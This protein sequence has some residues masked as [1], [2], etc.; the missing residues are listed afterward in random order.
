MTSR[1]PTQRSLNIWPRLGFA[2]VAGM[3][4]ALFTL[5]G[6]FTSVDRA[7]Q[8][9]VMRLAH[10]PAASDIVL[11]EIDDSSLNAYGSWP[12]SRERYVTLIKALDEAG[13][14]RIGLD[15]LLLESSSKSLN[16]DFALAEAL[17]D[18]GGVVLPVVPGEWQAESLPYEALPIPLL[19]QATDALGHGEF[20]LDS[21]GRVRRLYAYAGIGSPH[22]PAFAFAIGGAPAL[23]ERPT[24]PMQGWQR[25]DPVLIPFIGQARGYRRFSAGSI[26]SG[27]A[28][29]SG[30]DE[31][32]VLI[33]VTATG[34][35]SRY[36]VPDNAAR[37]L[38]TGLEIHANTLQA[39][40]DRELI[41][42]VQDIQAALLA[43]VL[44][45]VPLVFLP[46]NGALIPFLAM[47]AMLPVLVSVALFVLMQ[48]WWPPASALAG[49]ALSAPFWLGRRS[50]LR[51][52]Q[53][54][55]QRASITLASIGEAV[56]AADAE[57]RVTFMNRAAE[58]FANIVF[59]DADGRPL[60]QVLPLVDE[61]GG[62]PGERIASFLNAK[63]DRRIVRVVERPIHGAGRTSEGTVLVLSDI[64]EERALGD[65]ITFQALHDSLTELP[66]RRLLLQRLDEAIAQASTGQQRLAVLFIDLDRF[67]AINDGLGHSAGDNLL[68]AVA[69]RLV[70]TCGPEDT[71][72][73]L[74]G[75]EFVVVM[76]P[77]GDT[78][79]VRAIAQAMLEAIEEPLQLGEHEVQVSC[80]IGVGLCPDHGR[81][82]DALLR[83][84]D[85][86]MYEAKRS[87]VES[88]C[89][90]QT[91]LASGRNAGVGVILES[92]LRLAVKREE[93][94]L[95]VQPQ[96]E[97][98]TRYTTGVECLLRWRH[99]EQG[100]L[101]PE[102]FIAAAETSHLARSLEEWV[103]EE[104]CRLAARLRRD[105]EEPPRVA[106][107]LSS[108]QFV[109]ADLA[110]YLAGRLAFWSVEPQQFS[111]EITESLLPRELRA[112]RRTLGDLK[113]LGVHVAIDDFG[114]GYS[115]FSHL[116]T[117]FYDELKIDRSFIAALDKP[118]ARTIVRSLISL[119]H[120]LGKATVAEGVE[121]EAQASLLRTMRCDRAQGF[122]FGR[123]MEASAFLRHL[124]RRR[125]A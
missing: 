112:V 90:Y 14:A 56:V 52:L 55:R 108:R 88:I 78:T 36:A 9:Q 45:A 101:L 28:D 6:L 113:E 46:V 38:M 87:A 96:V 64:T 74:S 25:A 35:G 71:V 68:R 115:S 95:L 121:T 21:D 49:A 41:M 44:V 91:D 2:L 118:D 30:L 33:G 7:L 43:L 106:V 80:S 84:A 124:Q 3:L 79:A 103:I 47:L 114:T 29:L 99:P 94:R 93:L 107:N 77:V 66:N 75:D 110:A 5:G 89:I 116:T 72:A 111:V 18:H 39:Y 81:D 117:F 60:D 54:E 37:G 67:K 32:F 65:R 57:G 42:P 34:V 119:A 4:A 10:R 120:G 69:R 70:A 76:E 13:A 100:L 26:L 125:S 12:W 85:S 86:A 11:V 83:A 17:E 82:G 122:L 63:G 1:Q 31:A 102:S 92:A 97:L 51:A 73:R 62:T 8:D 20:T 19:A 58:R 53:Q 50:D 98:A 61:G 123:P 27:D 59:E 22:W 109:R 15:L 104:A 16:A 23:N 40:R 24:T 48:I 105:L